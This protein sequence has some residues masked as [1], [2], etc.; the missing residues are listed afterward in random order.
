VKAPGIKIAP[1]EEILCSSSSHVD[2]YTL[3]LQFPACDWAGYFLFAALHG[4]GRAR[5]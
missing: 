5:R 4:D 3:G 1:P 2:D